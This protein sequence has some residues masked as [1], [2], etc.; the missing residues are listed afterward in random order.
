M[1]ARRT[2]LALL[3][4]GC[5]A[6]RPDTA[7]LASHSPDEGGIGG[8]GIFGVADLLADGRVAVAG[9]PLRLD[10][11]LDRRPLAGETLVATA[12]RAAPGVLLATRTVAF[13]P[14]VGPL[15]RVAGGHAVL[16][17][18]VDLPPGTPVHGPH[19]A[20]LR[21]AAL[22]PGQLVAV[23][24]LW[25]NEAVLATRIDVLDG[26]A[27]AAV[28][29]LLRRDAGGWRIGATA[30]DMG[31][32]AAP[33]ADGMVAVQGRAEGARLVVATVAPGA[34]LP[35]AAAPL[36]VEGFVA[37]DGGGPG[38]HLSGLGLPLDPASTV[39][40]LAGQRRLLLGRNA[41]RFLAEAAV[42][43]PADP[44]ARARALAGPAARRA[45]ERWLA[46]G[47]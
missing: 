10:P 42:D 15:E 5:A 32:V 46:D 12:R 22:R 18:R 1:T 31:S 36:A 13:R 17:T 44:A 35:G 6:P 38:F 3:A 47:A 27:P 21:P 43:L 34:A 37:P 41:T 4:A 9:I 2:L 25:R 26:P 28:T 20:A 24:G 45:I 30:L 29:G 40:P 19:G 33:A 39:V 16:G 8:T 11:G 14:L 7:S 23:S